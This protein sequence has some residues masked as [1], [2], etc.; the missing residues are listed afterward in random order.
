VT[1]ADD[2][3]EPGDDFHAGRILSQLWL[4]RDICVELGRLVEP[5]ARHAV[6]TSDICDKWVAKWV[7]K[8]V[9]TSVG[10]R[11]ASTPS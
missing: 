4:I 5:T 10:N 8:W 3:A 6:A 9:D 1:R 7:A 2:R 11:S